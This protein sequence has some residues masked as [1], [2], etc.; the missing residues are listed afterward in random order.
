MITKPVK[1]VCETS[2]SEDKS[3]LPP[4][5]FSF[6]VTKMI[7]NGTLKFTQEA[8]KQEVEKNA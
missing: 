8:V 7:Q 3:P 6:I 5:A 4:E 1:F 2:H